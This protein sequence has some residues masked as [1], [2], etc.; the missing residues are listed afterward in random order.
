MGGVCPTSWDVWSGSSNISTPSLDCS[1]TIKGVQVGYAS[2]AADNCC[3]IVNDSNGGTGDVSSSNS[4]QVTVTPSIAWNG[5]YVTNTDAN[6]A[7]Q[8]AIVG[9]Q[10][11]LNGSPG[12][13]AWSV[14]PTA[15]GGFDVAPDQSSGQVEMLFVT[16]DPDV[17]FYW[18]N[19]GAK[20]VSY[21]VSGVAARVKFNVA[22]PQGSMGA[23]SLSDYAINI[24]SACGYLCVHYGPSGSSGGV[25]FINNYSAPD[26]GTFKWVQTGS[27]D[28]SRTNAS[29][30]TVQSLSCSSELDTSYPYDTNNPTNDSPSTQL[31]AGYSDRQEND[32]FI[33]T[34]MYQSSQGS[35]IPV[36]V[37]SVGWSFGYHV[38]SGDGGNTWVFASKTPAGTLNPAGS[39]TFPQWSG[40]LST[41]H[42]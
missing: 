12:G 4:A 20:N 22:A 33:M 14:D 15:V 30:Q 6:N 9:Q 28:N 29:T 41:C 1:N 25:H 8:D 34:L 27:S 37:A 40:N 36:P 42:F 10:I 13:G 7:A 35:S 32:S 3:S 39:T 2:I 26:G 11:F 16:S 5:N 23:S 17:L 18:V 31:L 19:G 24:D 38:T 21:T